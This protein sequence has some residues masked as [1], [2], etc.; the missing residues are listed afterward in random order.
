M[1]LARPTKAVYPA[2]LNRHGSEYVTS[3]RIT[4]L[5]LDP[6][7]TQQ[8]CTLWIG[9]AGG[10]VWRTSKA[11]AGDGGWTQVSGALPTSNVGS[12][13]YDAPRHTLY[14]GTGEANASGDSGAG[15]GVFKS[16]DGG[17]HWTEL[18]GSAPFTSRAVSTWPSTPRRRPLCYVTTTRAVRGVSSVTGGGV[19]IV[20]G[21]AQWGLYK[22]T[23]G[24]ASFTFIHNGAASPSVC[25]GDTTE[26]TGAG[27][28]SPRGVRSFAID[29]TDHN[30]LYAGSFSRGVWRSNDA[31][32]TWTQIKTPVASGADTTS[33]PMFAV[34]T[35]PNGDTRMYLG[36]GTAGNPAAGVV[37]Q[38]LRRAPVRRRSPACRATDPADRGYATYNYCTGQ[39][40]YD[41]FVYLPPGHPDIVYLGGSYPYGEDHSISNAR[42]V[43][44]SRDG[45][46]T[47]SDLTEDATSPTRPTAC[48]PTSTCWSPSP[49]TRCRS[50]RVPTAA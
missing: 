11:L 9:A 26:A 37:A 28:C 25:T 6:D 23:D 2:F 50:G 40:W 7:C 33:R 14:A 41:N 47:W 29:P 46:A 36:E 10:G 22:S 4:S 13:L 48:T 43:V 21:A 34:T 39:C 44:L 24:G 16:T 35:L 17:D 31:G 12:L 45:G 19:S 30:T 8:R 42:G 27:P 38:R 15:Q 32:A 20:P 49:T 3:G 1:D 18:S 5:A